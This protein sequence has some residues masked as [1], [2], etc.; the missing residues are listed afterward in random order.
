MKYFSVKELKKKGFKVEVLDAI[1]ESPNSPGESV[2]ED[3]D[4]V[5][6][7]LIKQ[8]REKETA[9]GQKGAENLFSDKVANSGEIFIVTGNEEDD[10]DRV[11]KLND[12]ISVQAKKSRFNVLKKEGGAVDEADLPDVRQDL[13]MQGHRQ[14]RDSLKGS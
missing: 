11:N 8:R 1:G 14:F 6:G 9:D 7:W 5:D 10:V 12:P 3:D 13:K 2:I 4:L